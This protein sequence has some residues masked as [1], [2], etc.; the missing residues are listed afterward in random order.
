MDI[1]K[2]K[3][4]IL[5]ED[6]K[7]IGQMLVRR[8]FA[9]G[10]EVEWAKNGEEGLEWIKT[11]EFDIIVTDIMMGKMDGYE[12]LEAVQQLEEKKD[13]PVVVLTNKSSMTDNSV[14]IDKLRI[15]AQITK[16]TTELSVI[17]KTIAEVYKNKKK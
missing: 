10:G 17:V 5:V 15:D 8:L 9:A 1:L 11:Q 7:F 16:A 14:D 12:M 13:I 3:K 4:I 6:D 2:G